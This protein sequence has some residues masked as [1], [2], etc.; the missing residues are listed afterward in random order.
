M[1]YFSFKFK[2]FLNEFLKK[3][4]ITPL[5]FNILLVSEAEYL[6][7]IAVVEREACPNIC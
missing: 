6:K 4:Y 5:S 7:Y 2:R 1:K 3:P